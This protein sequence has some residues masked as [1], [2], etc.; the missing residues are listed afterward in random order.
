MNREIKTQCYLFGHKLGD[1]D[2]GYP[3]C[4]R[5]KCHSYY[6]I[7]YYND[8]ILMRPFW[9]TRRKVYQAKCDIVYWFRSTFLGDNLPF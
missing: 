4:E 5:C 7:N 2:G 3:V 6:D 1:N 9:Y 8:A